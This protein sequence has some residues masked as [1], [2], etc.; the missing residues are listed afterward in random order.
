[1]KNTIYQHFIHKMWISGQRQTIDT[2]GKYCLTRIGLLHIIN[3]LMRKSEEV[4][5]YENDISA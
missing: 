3:M 2:I 4:Y 1:M 5:R